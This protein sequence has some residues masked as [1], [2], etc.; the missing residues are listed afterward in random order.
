MSHF[1]P[2]HTVQW[3]FEEPTVLRKFSLSLGEMAVLTG[4][5]LRLYRALVISHGATSSWFWVGGTFALGLLV[6][7]AMATV[8]LAN[9]PVR[10]WVWRAPLFAAIEA[11]AESVTA[12]ALIALGREPSGSTR[13][14]FSD[15]LP[16]AGDTLWTRELVICAWALVLAGVVS[17]VRRTILRQQKVEEE[18]EPVE[19]GA[20]A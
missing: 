14:E 10:R 1:F 18:P 7:C 2:K 16:M 11:A 15:W 6:L 8:H 13:A 9:Y 19:N 5:T 17:L 4:V 3:H 20:Q 12:L